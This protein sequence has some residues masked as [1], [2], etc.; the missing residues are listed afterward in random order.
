M[1]GLK[2]IAVKTASAW[3]F[4]EY[5]GM[6]WSNRV[7][8]DL[9]LY[10]PTTR[11]AWEAWI[12]DAKESA[13]QPIKHVAELVERHLYGIVNAITLGVS[14]GP[15]EGINSQIKRIK[16]MAWQRSSL[17]HV[18]VPYSSPWVDLGRE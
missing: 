12:K 10:R 16:M 13:L 3:K 11:E 5:A 1:E 6:L 2:E 17:P 14:N 8:P 9:G 7:I 18:L 4:K 15:A